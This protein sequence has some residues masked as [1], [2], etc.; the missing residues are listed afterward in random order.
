VY[1]LQDRA[2]VDPF[3]REHLQDNDILLTLGAGDVWKHGRA[4][5]GEEA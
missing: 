2:E 3:L 4:F 5:L 1:Y